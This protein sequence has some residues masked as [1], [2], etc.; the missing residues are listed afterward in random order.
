M[1]TKH[2]NHVVLYAK[3]FYR[4]TDNVVKDMQRFMQLDG[5]PF[6]M[7]NT[8]EKVVKVMRKNFLKWVESL[9]DTH[10]REHYTEWADG[11]VEWADGPAGKIYNML[12]VYSGG[13]IPMDSITL[14]YPKYD[15]YHLPQFNTIDGGFNSCMS[16][17]QM[18]ARAKE[19]L[20]ETHED[21]MDRF[22]NKLMDECDW[23]KRVNVIKIATG[24]VLTEEDLQ[25]ELWNLYTDF[26]DT[27]IDQS[28]HIVTP[29]YYQLYSKHFA[30]SI[31]TKNRYVDINCDTICNEVTYKYTH[32]GASHID[33]IKALMDMA[34]A[35]TRSINNAC[36]IANKINAEYNDE[37]FDSATDPHES[38]QCHADMFEDIKRYKTESDIEQHN[39]T[40]WSTGG[41]E[42][43]FKYNPDTN[44]YTLTLRLNGFFICSIAEREIRSCSCFI[45]GSR[46]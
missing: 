22:M 4:H 17:N 26:M 34:I 10:D 45:G 43:D 44:E 14:D 15:Q 19:I 2:I 36:D 24:E 27:N 13:M 39:G 46:N 11:T 23:E 16:Y 32:N 18:I 6:Y 37:F 29:G 1:K 31:N 30:L 12:I 28:T 41:H 3:N 7:I 35:D 8:P 25:D 21:R 40:C 5:C 42:Y 38:I 20:D 9:E 33:S